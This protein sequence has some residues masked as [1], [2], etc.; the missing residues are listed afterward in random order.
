ML[1]RL[2]ILVFSIFLGTT[3]FSQ[4]AYEWYQDGKVIFQLHISATP[5]KT[6]GNQV[7]LASVPALNEVQSIF[8]ITEVV[9]LHPDIKDEAL[10]KTYEIRFTSIYDVD[11]LV[12]RV[13]T[14]PNV[15]YAEKK[16]LHTNFLTPDD[17]SF[18][19]S[20]SNGQWGLFQI[21]AEQAWNISTGTSSVVVAVTDNAININHTENTYILFYE[22]SIQTKNISMLKDSWFVGPYN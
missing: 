13:Q 15:L 10:K 9:Q 19:T 18:T 16:E 12:R 14:M 3:S 17:P 6:N 20:F 11:A 2:S 5:L 8:G 21:D 4:N 7:E 22:K 1:K